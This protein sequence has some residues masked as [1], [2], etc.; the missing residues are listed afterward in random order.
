MQYFLM[1]SRALFG[2][3]K[4]RNDDSCKCEGMVGEQPITER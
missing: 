2:D 1:R 4:A 3:V